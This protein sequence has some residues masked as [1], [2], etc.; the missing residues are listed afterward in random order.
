VL[1][2]LA[3]KGIGAIGMKSLGGGN[4]KDGGVI[5]ASKVCAAEEAMRYALSQP[6]SSLVVGIDTEAYLD[7][8]LRIGANFTPMSDAEKTALQDRVKDV[9]GDGRLEGFKSTQAF[10]GPYHR[11]QHGFAV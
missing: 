10:D 7:Q 4:L 5:P 11:K 6:I 9:A 1:P 3:E 8:A 2:K